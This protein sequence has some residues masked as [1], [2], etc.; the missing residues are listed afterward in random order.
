V[1]VVGLGAGTLAAYGERGDVFRFYEINP[2][3]TQVAH[4]FFTYLADSKA[5]VEIALGDGRIQLENELLESGSQQFDLLVIDAFSSDAIPAHLLTAECVALY[6][7]HLKTDGLLLVHLSNRYVNLRPVIRGLVSQ[8]RLRGMWIVR[9]GRVRP[10]VLGSSWMIIGR[11]G[12]PIFE[13]K[14]VTDS[15]SGFPTAWETVGKAAT[16]L[17]L[18]RGQ[19]ERQMRE[20]QL[21]SKRDS[22]GLWVQVETDPPP[23]LWT[24]DRQSLWRVL[25]LR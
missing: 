19:I 23:L 20:G 24:D 5:R 6:L 9:G 14:E 10:G 16:R 13:A 3:V 21:A 1:G 15:A 22:T 8:F 4:Q 7:R 2:A 17:G 11:P 18:S 25:R 12:S